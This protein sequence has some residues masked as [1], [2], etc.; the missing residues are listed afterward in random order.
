MIEGVVTKEGR[1]EKGMTEGERK[2]GGVMK[3]R[4]S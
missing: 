2:G 1:T 4:R 3:G